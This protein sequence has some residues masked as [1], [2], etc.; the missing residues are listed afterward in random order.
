MRELLS[1]Q[2]SLDEHTNQVVLSSPADQLTLDDQRLTADPRVPL[3]LEVPLLLYLTRSYPGSAQIQRLLADFVSEIR[4]YL[5]PL[6]VERTVTGVPRIATNVR[7][8]SQRLRDRGLVSSSEKDRFRAWRLSP[9]GLVIGAYLTQ[10]VEWPGFPE[11]VSAAGAPLP[12]RI[13]DALRE[14]QNPKEQECV[15][16]SAM[17][18]NP[19]IVEVADKVRQ[20]LQESRKSRAS[21]SPLEERQAVPALGN[22]ASNQQAGQFNSDLLGWEQGELFQRSDVANAVVGTGAERAA[23][24][25]SGP[26]T[27]EA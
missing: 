11:R 17:T 10:V 8:A 20:L 12:D 14:L 4:P 5:S 27:T 13:E 23:A 26:G 18:R 2:I 9:L 19:H 6:D 16:S 24:G 25:A 21:S 3:E 7:F 22:G 15:I 1:L